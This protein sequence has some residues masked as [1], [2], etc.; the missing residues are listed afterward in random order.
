MIGTGPNWPKLA[1]GSVVFGFGFFSIGAQALL[2][3]QFLW[4]LEGH[5]IAV[6]LFL[7]CWL[8]WVAIGACIWRLIARIP[9]GSS[10]I[11]AIA[12]MAYVPAFALQF[13]LMLIIRQVG[14]SQAYMLLPLGRLL[15]W[16]F[17]VCAPVSL[18]T[19]L[20]FAQLCR[21]LSDLTR[22]PITVAYVL[23]SSGS[24]VG[25]M[26]TTLLLAEGWS[27]PAVWLLLSAVLAGLSAWALLMYEPRWS[28]WLV[29]LLAVVLVVGLA[30]GLGSYLDRFVQIANWSRILPPGAF[31]GSFGTAQGQ[32]LYGSYK[33]QFVVVSNGHVVEGLPETEGQRLLAAVAV[34]QRPQASRYL[35]VGGGIG[36]CTALLKLEGVGLVGLVRADPQYLSRLL[37]HIPADLRVSDRRFLVVQQDIRAYLRKTQSLYDAV[38]IDPAG[39]I[40]GANNRLY[41]KEFLELVKTRLAPEG[42]VVVVIPGGENVIGP[43]LAYLGASVIGTLRQVFGNLWL[44]PG[45]QTVLLASDGPLVEDPSRLKDGLLMA[46]GSASLYPAD[47]LA[48]MIQKER[49]SQALATYD[50]VTRYTGHL[51]NRDSRP[52]SYLYGLLLSARHA[53]LPAIKL[54]QKAEHIGLALTF[55]PAV[56]LVLLW[57]AYLLQNRTRAEVAGRTSAGFVGGFAVLSAGFVGICTVITLLSLHQSVFGSLYVY[58]GLV[59]GLFMAGLCLGAIAMHALVRPMGSRWSFLGLVVVHLLLL[60]WVARLTDMPDPR[61]PILAVTFIAVG[62]CSGAYLPW[63]ARLAENDRVEVGTT[64]ARLQLLDHVG[65]AIGGLAGSLVLVPTLGLAKTMLAVAGLLAA[66]IPLELGRHLRFRT[67]RRTAPI[68]VDL[69]LRQIGYVLAGIAASCLAW[70]M[71]ADRPVVARPDQVQGLLQM[72]SSWTAGKDV[73]SEAT[74]APDGGRVYYLKVYHH[75]RLEGYV[76]ATDPFVQVRGYGGPLSMV[77][78][79][80][81]NGGLLD[82]RFVRCS[83]TPR[84]LNRVVTW[85]GNIKGTRLWGPEML[86]DVHAVTGATV[87][88]S[89]VLQLLRSSGTGF[90]KLVLKMEDSHITAKVSVWDKQGLYLLASILGAVVVSIVGRPGLRVVVLALAFLVGGIWLNNQYSSEQVLGL[91][92]ARL[93]AVGLNGAM[94]LL[95]VPF[96]V[97][98]LGNIYCGYICPF[99]GFQELVSLLLPDRLRP[100]VARTAMQKA[101]FIKYI[102]LFAFVVGFC[103]TG[104]KGAYSRDILLRVFD[105]RSWGQGLRSQWQFIAVISLLVLGIVIFRRFWCRYL[106]PAGAFLS[107]FNRLAFVG[108]RLLPTKRFGCCEFGL[109]G[110]DHLDC[111]WCDRCMVE[112]PTTRTKADPGKV[113]SAVLIIMVLTIAIWLVGGVIERPAAM[114]RAIA[115]PQASTATTPIRGQGRQVDVE[116]IKAMIDQGQLSDREAMYYKALGPE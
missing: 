82:H 3:R 1:R 76:F 90:A 37:G 51:V 42:L 81:P 88:S 59:S 108:R 50:Q 94:L 75:G 62:L 104:Q 28:G 56:V 77:L 43:E 83:E 52:I 98:I 27:G 86:K 9:V 100:V 101:R 71:L 26:I 36:I 4:S 14:G 89:A 49:V 35:V 24:L 67:A 96:M 74:L 17:L 29:G 61:L 19:G 66:N 97:A 92:W 73:I 2:F 5:D 13:V 33:G 84:Y 106:C 85:L 21:W 63:A 58:M 65:S 38:I 93:P 113:W 70:S 16:S 102:V 112:D 46:K 30:S 116:R 53:G 6:G 55:V 57:W 99:G 15:I 80:D 64:A 23:E 20:F 95:L 11:W 7:A 8:I 40:N 12:P 109:T 44:L 69:R 39:T 10:R 60:I 103:L 110:L 48:S 114:P 68:V 22:W 72:A 54:A 47:G 18:V 105:W 115:V 34:S 31:E 87:S 25:G 78:F 45:E 79:V 41:T 91:L 107:L 111:I 32:Y